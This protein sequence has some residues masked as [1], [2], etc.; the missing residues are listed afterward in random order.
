MANRGA[1][2]AFTASSHPAPDAADLPGKVKRSSP[3]LGRVA[4][5]GHVF[6]LPLG[7]LGRVAR[8][9]RAGRHRASAIPNK[10][11]HK[12]DDTRPRRGEYGT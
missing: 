10:L 8:N 2:L 9:E 5:D 12:V 11:R 1:S 6:T 4:R 3:F 7:P